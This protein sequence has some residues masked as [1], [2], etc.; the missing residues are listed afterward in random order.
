[1]LSRIADA[2]FWIGRYVERAEQTSRILD[3]GLESVAERAQQPV[4][5]QSL[6]LLGIVGLAAQA[7]EQCTPQ[8]VVD[9]LATDPH[10]PS[11]VAGALSAARDNARGARDVLTGEAFE[12]LNVLSRLMPATGD[13]GHMHAVMRA[14]GRGCATFFGTVDAFMPRDEA[15]IFLRIGRLLERLDMTARLLRASA[16]GTDLM[17]ASAL[18]RS[19]GAYEPFLRRSRG[20]LDRREAVEFLLLDELCPRSAVHCL[21][22]LGSAIEMLALLHGRRRRFG[23]QDAPERLVG[24]AM[25]SLRF[26]PLNAILADLP[27]EMA[28]LQAAAAA[29]ADA[30]DRAY[31]H[32]EA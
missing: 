26:R 1:M 9:L 17:D 28:D 3:I 16:D 14:T 30:V 32:P 22:R 29:L 24:Q 18:L 2:L 6:H 11:S 10:S 21:D 7:P 13:P 5:A 23:E 27:G 4:R 25:A 12:T 15:W 8:D 31:I 20:Q 19:C